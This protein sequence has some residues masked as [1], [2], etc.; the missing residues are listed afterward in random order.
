MLSRGHFEMT[1]E[2]TLQNWTVPSSANESEKQDRTE[3]MIREAIADHDAFST[4]RVEVFAKGSYANNTNVRFDSDV[5]I[6]VKCMEAEYWDEASSGVHTPT[7]TYEGIWTPGRFRAEVEAALRNAFGGNQVD[8]SGETALIVRSSTARVDA[9]VV[10]CFSYRY[11]FQNG[12]SREGTKVWKKS[13][14]GLVNYPEQ[15]L[16]N[17]RAKNVR[18]NHGYKKVVRILKRVGIS[19]ADSGMSPPV[20]SFLIECLSYNCPDRLFFGASWKEIV[21]AVLI[22][23][24][25]S[26]AGMEPTDSSSRL[27]EANE[28]LFLFHPQQKWTRAEAREFV[29]EAWRY[30]GFS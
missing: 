18:T 28:C 14:G 26:L 27:L 24:W 21:R 30:L 12:G 23:L 19:L 11:Y 2:E 22:H 7:S 25:N 9:D 16:T 5:D 4:C 13:G 20:L 29:A 8:S 6:A 3:R 1:L 10:P 17:G 15:Q